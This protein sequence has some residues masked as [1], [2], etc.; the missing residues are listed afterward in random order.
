MLLGGGAVDDCDA[1]AVRADGAV[2]LGCHSDSRDL[3]GPEGAAYAIT[4]DLDAF[5]FKFTPDGR[6]VAYRTQFG[7]VGWEA[8]TGIAVDANGYAYAVGATYSAD[9]AT[10]AGAA[11]PRHGGGGDDAFVARL[12]PAGTVVYLTYLGGSGR[13][14]AMGV[15]TDGAGNAYV[16]G[17]TASPNFPT[18]PD[19]LQSLYRGVTD[20]FLTTLDPSGRIV[21][22]TYFGGTGHDAAMAVGLD[23]AGNIHVAG[24]T[25]STDFPL[26]KGLQPTHRGESDGFV[27]V[28]DRSGRQL[29]FSS[30][31]GGSGWDAFNALMV[32]AA[33]HIYLTGSTRSPDFPVS[34]QAV[35]TTP[36]GGEDASLARLEA[37]GKGVVYSTYLGGTGNESGAQVVPAT[38]GVFVVGGT[39]SPDFPTVGPLQASLRGTLSGYVTLLDHGGTRLLFS[40]YFGGSDRDLFEDAAPHPGGG[41][42]V[43]GLTG[44]ADFPMVGGMTRGF[45]GG[46]RDI[47]VVKFDV[48]APL[49]DD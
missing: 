25:Q 30:L 23:R 9:L 13:D 45:A 11:Q 34:A 43:T 10:T 42:V 18:S 32:D 31:W 5:V 47:L 49:R 14:D 48:G 39:E 38:H 4:G 3:P 7:G 24:Q 20:A 21:Y 36:G 1:V 46:W 40:T 12:D 6:R 16:V 28:V 35:Q 41:L 29:L 17:R 26:V 37:M 44:S 15:T 27:V 22:S 33:G 2:Y 19:A 8:V